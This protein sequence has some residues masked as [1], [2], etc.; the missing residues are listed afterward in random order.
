MLI[1]MVCSGNLLAA[2]GSETPRSGFAVV[3]V[4]SGNIENLVTTESLTNNISGTVEQAT[5]PPSPL[6]TS[7]SILV[8]FGSSSQPTSAIAVA[9]PST[10]TGGVNL[11]LTDGRGGIVSTA[12]VHLGP[13]GHISAFLTDLFAIE[14]TQVPSPLLLTLSSEI[15]VAVLAFNFQGAAFDAIPITT[16]NRIAPRA[17]GLT[18]SARTIGGNAVVFGQVAAG[19]GWSS[20]IVIFNTSDGN[21]TVRVDFFGTNGVSFGS[22]VDIVVPPRGIAILPTDSLVFG[23]Q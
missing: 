22:L 2:T 5:L 12:T 1:L 3:T 9:N 17:T 6:I 23:L 15:P 21:N 13:R 18:P 7:A 10:V 8:S 16:G 19:G 4:V 11:L 14:P 20:Q